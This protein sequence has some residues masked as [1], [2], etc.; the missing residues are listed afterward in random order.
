MRKLL[1]LPDN[2]W[3]LEEQSKA[4]LLA[5]EGKTDLLVALPMGSRKSIMLASA[6]TNKTFAIVV[7]FILLLED[8]KHH[9]KMARIFYGVF[10]LGMQTFAN[11]PI[12]LATTDI[13]VK[14]DFAE[15][16]GRLFANGM[17]GGLVLDEVH[18]VFASRDFQACMQ[19][20][21]Q[22]RRLGFLVVGMSGMIPVE[23]ES[24]LRRKL[25]LVKDTVVIHWSSN[26]PELEYF[27]DPPLTDTTLVHQWME[28]IVKKQK[29]SPG[30]KG[31]VFVTSVSN[32]YTL[33][34]LLKCDFYCTT[35][36]VKESGDNERPGT[37][38]FRPALALRSEA[39]AKW[40]QGINPIIVVMTM[41]AAENDFSYVMF[42][43]LAITPFDMCSAI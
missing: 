6:L 33:A 40:R 16:I 1:W 26:R 14:S 37:K 19:S 43:I 42:V 11:T 4:A 15:A 38:G 21:W 27:I 32:G 24:L 7:P 28:E 22:I 29:M 23:M 34:L 10:K 41:F 5:V 35:K 25:C 13:A 18:K 9:L 20:I 3:M 8:W 17:F 30:D 39:V 12:I 31:L 2:K 36:S